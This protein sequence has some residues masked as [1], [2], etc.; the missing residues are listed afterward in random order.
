MNLSV[1]STLANLAL[2]HR[3]TLNCSI[4]DVLALI[5]A[6]PAWGSPA[7]VAARL[8]AHFGTSLTGAY[9]DPETVMTGLGDASISPFSPP[10]G[11]IADVIDTPNSREFAAFADR[12]N[13]IDSRW[14]VLRSQIAHRLRWLGSCHD[15]V[16]L[17]SDM[18]TIEKL[19]NVL[20]NLLVDCRLPC[21]LLP[22][23]YQ[24]SASFERVAIGWNNSVSAARAI[25]AA[26][27]LLAQASEIYLLDGTMRSPGKRDEFP[28]FDPYQYLARDGVS[29]VAI[30][31]AEDATGELLLSS[32]R[33]LHA[34]LLVIGAYSHSPLRERILGG[35]T[36]Y[37]MEYS[38]MPLF[39]HH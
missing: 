38:D 4:G 18:A 39:L 27:P 1:R 6:G 23:D 28:H 11:G 2:P 19:R 22:P 36:R 16:V 5:T 35:V 3:D 13:V 20:A 32:A 12:H 7:R 30:E 14:T 21:L 34:E 33:D 26:R 9:F 8:A 37:L 25:H 31:V 17:E 15:L 29:I 24:G 10:I